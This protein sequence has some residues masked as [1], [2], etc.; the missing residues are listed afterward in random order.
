MP[1]LGLPALD[2]IRA[3]AV[4]A[5]ELPARLRTSGRSKRAGSRT[6]SRF[7]VIRYATSPKP[8]RVR[9]VLKGGAVVKNDLADVGEKTN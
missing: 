9:F 2:T 3:A 4:N 7:R 8:E 6:S 1:K 5:A